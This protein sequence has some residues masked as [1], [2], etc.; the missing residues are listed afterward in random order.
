MKERPLHEKV[1][2]LTSMMM[3]LVYAGG[4]IY[5]IASSS[6]FNL[7]PAGSWGRYLLSAALIAYGVYR[8]YR[9]W[10]NWERSEE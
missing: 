1:S 5:L 10:K 8:G 4:G 3:A 7:I 2:I 9:A 6:S